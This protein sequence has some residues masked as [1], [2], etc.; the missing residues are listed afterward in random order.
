MSLHQFVGDV[1]MYAVGVIL[2]GVIRGEGCSCSDKVTLASSP[3]E[4]AQRGVPPRSDDPQ[5][6]AG[7]EFYRDAHDG[8]FKSVAVREWQAP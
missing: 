2:V 3:A 4:D 6:G 7:L 1:S 8:V 5:P